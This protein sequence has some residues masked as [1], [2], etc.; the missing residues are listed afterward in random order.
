METIVE[1]IENFRLDYNPYGAEAFEI[2]S[3]RQDDPNIL[4]DALAKYESARLTRVLIFPLAAK[5]H[6]LGFLIVIWDRLFH[7]I[8]ASFS[9]INTIK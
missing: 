6:G 2:A 1:T 3:R 9:K 8:N 4:T 7:F 5:F